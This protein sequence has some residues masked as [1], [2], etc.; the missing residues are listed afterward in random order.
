MDAIAIFTMIC[1]CLPQ[2]N[3]IKLIFF[4]LFCSERRNCDVCLKPKSW[5]LNLSRIVQLR[6]MDGQT[7]GKMEHPGKRL[8]W[9]GTPGVSSSTEEIEQ[10]KDKWDGALCLRVANQT[11]HSVPLALSASPNTL[12]QSSVSSTQDLT[13]RC[14]FLLFGL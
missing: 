10:T 2:V 9:S 14:L 11:G 13:W 8:R 6:W 7:E 5:I 1:L 12:K 3:L 4:L